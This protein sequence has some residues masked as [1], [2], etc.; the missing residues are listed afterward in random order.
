MKVYA[1]LVSFAPASWG[2]ERAPNGSS[3]VRAV[4]VAKSG[5]EFRRLLAAHGYDAT[6]REYNFGGGETGNDREIEAA[7]SAPGTVFHE[8]SATS[9]TQPLRPAPLK[10]S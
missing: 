7:T 8:I 10:E 6:V 9:G 5:A 3:Q 1:M 4:A 2:V